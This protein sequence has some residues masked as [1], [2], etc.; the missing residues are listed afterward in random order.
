MEF[1]EDFAVPIEG[2]LGDSCVRLNDLK[3][4]FSLRWG[5]IRFQV[6]WGSEVNLKV[7]LRV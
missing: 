3:E 1:A 5:R 4:P 6:F 7:L 2:E